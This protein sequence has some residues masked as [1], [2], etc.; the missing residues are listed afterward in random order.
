[1]D[2][3]LQVNA[4]IHNI[5]ILYYI[6]YIVYIMCVLIRDH[7]TRRFTV[8]WFT[9]ALCN[10]I[11]YVCMVD[12]SD[13]LVETWKCHQSFLYTLLPS[14]SKNQWKSFV[15][16]FIFRFQLSLLLLL[17]LML[18]MLLVF[19]LSRKM[20]FKYQWNNNKTT[21]TIVWNKIVF[22]ISAKSYKFHLIPQSFYWA[23][24]TGR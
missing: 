21:R 24:C 13:I 7:I 10:N 1:M 18:L 14:E 6:G 17:M 20:C 23:S 12:L 11:K 19:Q 16:S 2:G 9:C 4:N 15:F 22:W 3:I 5:I 8:L